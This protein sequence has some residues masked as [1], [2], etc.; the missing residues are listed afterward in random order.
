[1]WVWYQEKP[2]LDMPGSVSPCYS[3]AIPESA[4]A[5]YPPLKVTVVKTNMKPNVPRLCCW[6]W[7]NTV[8]ISMLSWMLLTHLQ[9]H[10]IIPFKSLVSVYCQSVSTWWSKNFP[11]KR[12][13]FRFLKKSFSTSPN[14]PNW[15]VTSYFRASINVLK[16]DHKCLTKSAFKG[17]IVF[18]FFLVGPLR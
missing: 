18:F 16:A 8:S 7:L 10:S 6:L 3:L 11:Y 2:A 5:N 14:T 15:K 1:M 17:Q 13:E 9:L 4:S 12:M